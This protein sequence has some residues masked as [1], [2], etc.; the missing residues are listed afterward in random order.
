MRL[1]PSSVV[2]S[3]GGAASFA[4]AVGLNRSPDELLRFFRAISGVWDRI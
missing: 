2:K 3:Q 1:L 4:P